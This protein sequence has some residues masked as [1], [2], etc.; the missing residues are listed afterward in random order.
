M[1]ELDLMC[2]HCG[3]RFSQRQRV[4]GLVPKHELTRGEY[5]QIWCPGSEQNPRNAETD[6]RVLWKDLPI[7]QPKEEPKMDVLT[8]LDELRQMKAELVKVTAERDALRL[9]V[10][11]WI[12]SVSPPPEEAYPR[13]GGGNSE[14][15]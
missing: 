9:Q 13:H 3:R 10:Q 11:G 15:I 4:N 6:K 12:H 7:N 2:P 5:Y 14:G 8:L 1:E